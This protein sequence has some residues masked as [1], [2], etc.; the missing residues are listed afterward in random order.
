MDF[1]FAELMIW[2][3]GAGYGRFSLGIAPL[4]GI[5]GRRLAPVWARAATLLFRYGDRFYG[6]QGLRAYKAK[7]QPNWEPRYVAGTGGLAMVQAMRDLARL[8]GRGGTS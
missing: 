7:F 8:I 5:E 4:A 2:S 1:L 6:F 3:R